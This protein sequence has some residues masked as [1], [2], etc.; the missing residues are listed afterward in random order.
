MNASLN[1][2]SIGSRLRRSL[3][4]GA[5]VCS[6]AFG[7]QAAAEAEAAA[8]ASVAPPSQPNIIVLLVDDAG[9]MDFQPFGGEARMPNIQQLADQGVSFTH[10]R[11]SPLCAPSRAMLLTGV[12]NH[13][14]GVATIPEILPPEHAQ[15]PGYSMSLEPGVLTIAD[16]LRQ[17]NYRT[18]MTGKWHLNTN[19]TGLPINHGFDRSFALNASGAD[20]WEQRPYMAYYKTAPWY[21]DDQPASLPEDFY[22]SKFIVDKMIEY[23]DNGKQQ[24]QA[25]SQQPFFA[26]LAFQAI[27]I[28]LQAP[29]EF[30]EHYKGVYDK[31][32][33][34]LR[35]ARWEKAQ[36]LKLIP[37]GAPL[38]DMPDT[39]RRWDSLS[40]EERRYY[41]KAMAVNA[42]MLEAMDFH[43]GR[44]MTWLEEQ[45]ELENTL[46]VVT[47]DNGPEF[48]DML[49]TPGVNFWKA[50]SGYNSDIETLGEK[51]SLA[52][53][54]PEWA[55]AAAAPSKLFKFYAS[56]GGIRVPL[57]IAGPQLPKGVTQSSFSMV[58]DITPTLLDLAG[59]PAQQQPHEMAMSGRSLKPV[60]EG[61]AKHTYATDEAV[62]LEVT[63]N[64]ALFKGDYKLSRNLPPYGNGN[65][66]LYNI[67]L[68]PGE[69]Q[70]LAELQP[71][72]LQAL[73]TDYQS[74]A[75]TY[76]VQEIPKGFNSL[77]QLIFNTLRKFLSNYPLIIAFLSMSIIALFSWLAFLLIKR[78]Q[79]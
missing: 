75:A 6:G 30:T 15:A 19:L 67:A 47:S 43:I 17:H 48:N 52:S 36:Q 63:G 73:L 46:F 58:T 74:Y 5:L 78:I 77:D 32:W 28:P 3:V 76:G 41:S 14:T 72:R 38:S 37:H 57:I 2:S 53:I 25:N 10:Y 61:K 51:G 33:H 60:I 40:D 54:G 44:L 62:G 1:T 20:N 70:D 56:E 8:E 7:L 66:R 34:A 26:Y 21:E 79:H 69:T 64:A 4:L 45:G 31:G 59:L 16:R 27:H 65:W 9:L 11:T 39:A 12:D 50:I 68:D 22:S 23:I 13:Q 49:R 29:K 42:G 35:Q 18:Y 71:E 24:D 55:N